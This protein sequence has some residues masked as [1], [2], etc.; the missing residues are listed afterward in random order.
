MR[1]TDKDTPSRRMNRGAEFNRPTNL[2]LTSSTMLGGGR[3]R[4]GGSLDETKHGKGNNINGKRKSKLVTKA[5]V[6]ERKSGEKGERE[7]E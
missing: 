7:E 6:N 2:N 3:S 4:K 1:I 5:K